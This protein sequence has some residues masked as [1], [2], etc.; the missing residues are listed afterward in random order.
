MILFPCPETPDA[1]RTGLARTPPMGWSSWYFNIFDM[2]E[3]VWNAT[4]DAL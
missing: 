3:T 1:R 4:V 2:D